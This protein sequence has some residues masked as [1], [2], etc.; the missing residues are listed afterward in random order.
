MLSG[1]E[2]QRFYTQ[3]LQKIT[4]RLSMAISPASVEVLKLSKHT[5]RKLVKNFYFDDKQRVTRRYWK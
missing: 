2:F 1:L 3:T 5:G 4:T